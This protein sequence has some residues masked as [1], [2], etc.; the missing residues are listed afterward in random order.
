[1]ISQNFIYLALI[2]NIIGNFSYLKAVI[3]GRAKPHKVTWF[4]WAL[5]P[6][7]GFAAQVTQG[8]GISSLMTFAIG[9]GPVLVFMASFLNKKS[10]WRINRFDWF[11]GSISVLAI[12]FWFITKDAMVALILSLTADA[13][14]CIPTL[15]K[16]WYFPETEEYKAYLFAGV[17]AFITTL[18]LQVWDFQTY[19][20][21]VWTLVVCVIFVALIKFKIGRKIT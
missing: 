1:M 15:I 9:F 17:S 21:P 16:S 20:F 11:C 13:V 8:V 5:A 2:F 10:D 3:Q 12:V 19:A 4:L 7:I 14:A 18:S 6:L